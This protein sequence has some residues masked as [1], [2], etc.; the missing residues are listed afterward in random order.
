MSHQ[1]TSGRR[2]SLIKHIYRGKP[3]EYELEM[4]LAPKVS[5]RS[6]LDPVYYVLCAAGMPRD[7]PDM[8]FPEFAKDEAHLNSV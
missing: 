8:I 4:T 7:N 2:A 6:I 5:Q 1:R 3:L